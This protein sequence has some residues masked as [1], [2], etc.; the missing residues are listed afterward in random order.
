M[1][2]GW[3]RVLVI[4]S[5]RTELWWLRLLKPGF[6]H[7]SLALCG[8]RGWLLLDPLSHQTLITDTGLPPGADLAGHYRA[9][10]LT[11]LETRLRAAPR[12]LAPVRPLTCVEMAKHVL[13]LHAPWVLTPWQLYRKIILDT[14]TKQE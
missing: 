6:R 8:P 3:S 10:G 1:S 4:F 7:V 5:G 9:L 2:P 13:G 14:G 12:R 11:V